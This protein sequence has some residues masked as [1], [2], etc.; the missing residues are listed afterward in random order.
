MAHV[1]AKFLIASM[2]EL[3]CQ[4]QPFEHVPQQE[5]RCAIRFDQHLIVAPQSNASVTTACGCGAPIFPRYILG[6]SQKSGPGLE[7]FKPFFGWVA[8]VLRKTHLVVNVNPDMTRQLRTEPR[9]HASSQLLLVS[10]LQRPSQ[11]QSRNTPAT[12]PGAS[13]YSFRLCAAQRHTL[14]N[15]ASFDFALASM[16]ATRATTAA[17]TTM[18]ARTEVTCLLVAPTSTVRSPSCC[19]S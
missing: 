2:E 1:A 4:S 3:L 17:G 10:S 18:M 5:G 6:S 7:S 12:Y 15:R 14:A 19:F 8:E 11:A 16:S 9:R 13:N